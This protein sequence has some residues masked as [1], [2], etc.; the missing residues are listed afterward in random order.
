MY[1][2]LMF[3]IAFAYAPIAYAQCDPNIEPSSSSSLR[4]QPRGNR[5]EGFYR[6]K[7]GSAS[8]ELISCT[9]GEFR[10]K[11]EASEVITLSLPATTKQAVKVRAQGIPLN[12]YYRM[13]AS[14]EAGKPLNWE[15][16][17]ILLRD[18]ITSRD[19]NI[20]L[21]A[22]QGEGVQQV[23]FPVAS[24]SKLLAKSSVKDSLILQFMGSARMASFKWQIDAGPLTPL[25]GSLPDGRPVRLK[26]SANLPKGPHTLT[27]KYRAQN[28]DKETTRRY[29]L[30]L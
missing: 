20:G 11:N 19:Y 13:D 3:F 1:H 21:L 22:F 26:I 30:Q 16:A 18:P 5:C 4:Y 6:S 9:L 28:D 15:P 7:V 29:Q 27:V 14:L 25:K 12:L 23:F 2:W 8:L 24:Q 17:A 10:F